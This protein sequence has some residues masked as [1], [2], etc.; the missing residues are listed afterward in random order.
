M[1]AFVYAKTNLGEGRWTVPILVSYLAPPQ[2]AADPE[3]KT[4]TERSL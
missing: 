3:L 4:K 1:T 2:E